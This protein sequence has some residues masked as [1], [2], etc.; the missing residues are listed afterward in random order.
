M[1]TI[2]ELPGPLLRE[3]RRIAARE[4]ATLKLRR[5]GSR[6]A[7]CAVGVCRMAGPLRLTRPTTLSGGDVIR[8]METSC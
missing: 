5:G 7:Y 6:V 1:K 4:G 8:H 2:V 3:V